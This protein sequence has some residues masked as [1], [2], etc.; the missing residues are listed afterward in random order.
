MTKLKG[1]LK[2]LNKQVNDSKDILTLGRSHGV[3]AEPMLMGQ[4]WFGH[5]AEFKRRLTD[6]ENFS[7]TGQLSGT[8]GNYTIL[9]TQIEKEA[10]ESLKLKVE[11]ASTQVIPRDRIAS[12]VQQFSLLGVAIERLAV[13]IRHLHHSDVNEV[14][15]GFSSGQK[16]SSA[17]PHKKNPI[18]S[19][20]LS[21]LARMLKSFSSM[22]LDNC[23]LWHERD[24]SHS[25][26]ERM[27][28]PDMFGIAVYAL[29]R[30]ANTLDNITY[31]KE[32]ILIQKIKRL[33]IYKVIQ[34]REEGRNIEFTTK[35]E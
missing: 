15:E 26:N 32:N 6:F 12:L 21:G 22:A 16:G 9:N 4:K 24:I 35:S 23:I 3:Y 28:L 1:V 19:E 31:N 25:S 33:E 14:C 34:A 20:N 13:E 5:M 10:I 29:E 2:S 27:Y 17:M 8:V 30:L 18:S 11:V 7:F